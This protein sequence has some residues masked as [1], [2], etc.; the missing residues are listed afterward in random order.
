MISTKWR[1]LVQTDYSENTTKQMS[2]NISIYLYN[3][4]RFTLSTVFDI[5][6]TQKKHDIEV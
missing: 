2:F 5:S 4:F 3:D 1:N 6:L